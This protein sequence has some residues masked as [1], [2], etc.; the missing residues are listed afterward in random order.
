MQI[1]NSQVYM[2]LLCVTLHQCNEIYEVFIIN[3]E[4]GQKWH[5]F[6]LLVQDD[7]SLVDHL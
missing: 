1:C 5:T 4:Y 3:V 6:E 2:K 7:A